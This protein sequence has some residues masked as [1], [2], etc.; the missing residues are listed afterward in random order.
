MIVIVPSAVNEDEAALPGIV[1]DVADPA[2]VQLWTVVS[3]ITNTAGTPASAN[4]PY[5]NVGFAGDGKH[6]LHRY[7]TVERNHDVYVIV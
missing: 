2:A 1:Q 7:Q 3:W 6:R 4:V 5:S